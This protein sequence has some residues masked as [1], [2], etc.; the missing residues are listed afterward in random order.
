M[1]QHKRQCDL[2]VH[3]WE[4]SGALQWQLCPCSPHGLETPPLGVRYHKV[5]GHWSSLWEQ[6]QAGNKTCCSPLLWSALAK[7][8][9]IM[10]RTMRNGSVVFMPGCDNSG[11]LP[12]TYPRFLN[13]HR[14]RV[15]LPWLS[16]GTV[17]PWLLKLFWEHLP[18]SLCWEHLHSL[19][20]FSPLMLLQFST[21]DF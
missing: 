4:G 14:L 18:K 3:Y 17:A 2:G 5:L 10:A 6:R 8:F 1:S 19:V 12:C 13:N 11:S 15:T 16:L 21:T 9:P 20:L 7:T